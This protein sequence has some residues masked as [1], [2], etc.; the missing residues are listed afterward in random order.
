MLPVLGIVLVLGGYL[1]FGNLNKNLVYYL[2]PG[3]AMAK[4]ADFPD[5]RRFRMGGFVE[6]GSVAR[7]ADTVSFVIDGGGARVRVVHGGAPAQ[8]F[9][10]GIGVI[11]EGA[12]DGDIFRSDTMIVKHDENYHP[13]AQTPRPTSR[14]GQQ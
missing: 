3:E 4:K 13:P 10:A 2:T 1:M 7:G 11:V 9:R 5:G 14:G 6:E 8:L 12:W